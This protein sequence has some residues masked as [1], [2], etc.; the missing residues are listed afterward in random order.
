V[1]TIRISAVITPP[2]G[3]RGGKV[4]MWVF[5]VLFSEVKDQAGMNP[6]G[7]TQVRSF[8]GQLLSGVER[9]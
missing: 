9:S 2:A 5:I 1:N 6:E 8:K 3:K 4:A 7:S